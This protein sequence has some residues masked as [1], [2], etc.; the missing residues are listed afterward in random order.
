MGREI[1]EREDLR[2]LMEEYNGFRDGCL[3]EM[4]YGSGAFFLA[5]RR[6]ACVL[7]FVPR[8]ISL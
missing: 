8:I 4:Q 6:P 3:T 5:V 7:C 1:T 2:S